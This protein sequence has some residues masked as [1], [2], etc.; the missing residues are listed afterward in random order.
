MSLTSSLRT[1]AADG[2]L[3]IC[4][5]SMICPPPRFSAGPRSP[6]QA[7]DPGQWYRDPVRAVVEVVTELVAGLLELG[8]CAGPPHRLGGSRQEAL[9][10]LAGRHHVAAK[11]SAGGQ[12]LP[13][14]EGGTEPGTPGFGQGGERGLDD[15][16]ERA[17]HARHV[18]E[19]T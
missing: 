6:Q 2:S 5:R 3:R 11:K 12:P 19:R 1:P 14:L 17:Q 4:F 8:G 15:V 16:V 13:G 10:A 18:A 9:R 7:P